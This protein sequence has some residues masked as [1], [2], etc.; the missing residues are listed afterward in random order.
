M[1]SYISEKWA[2]IAL[3]ICRDF[4]ACYRLPVWLS[5]PQFL[6]E[7]LTPSMMVFGWSKEVIKVK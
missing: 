1:N 6:A 4:T 3:F 2:N 7:T 5:S